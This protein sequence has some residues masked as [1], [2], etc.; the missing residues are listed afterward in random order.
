MTKHGQTRKTAKREA[1]RAARQFERLG[2]GHW[3]RDTTPQ[4]EAIILQA[5]REARAE[6]IAKRIKEPAK[7]KPRTP[8]RNAMAGLPPTVARWADKVK[9]P[10]VT[11]TN[12]AVA[13]SLRRIA[14]DARVVAEIDRLVKS[15]R[16]ASRFAVL[17]AACA[18][19]QR[20]EG[21]DRHRPRK[22]RDDLEREARAICPANGPKV[23][24][25]AAIR[26]LK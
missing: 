5:K 4:E 7:T 1:K 2:A 15:G 24:L 12:K 11:A 13:R 9:G 22:T 17:E 26:D 14:L 25:T 23:N 20:A 21:I 3:Q 10:G 16:Y 6:L 8:R 18:A 19:L